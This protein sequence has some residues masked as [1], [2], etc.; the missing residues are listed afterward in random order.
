[1]TVTVGNDTSCKLAAST[2]NGRVYFPGQK[3][4]W[5]KR[6]MK[7]RSVHETLGEGGGTLKLSVQ[8]GAIKVRHAKA[9]G[10]S[11]DDDS[12]ESD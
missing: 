6:M 5:I 12:D 1:M 8:N 10:D 3:H 9:D 2:V 4:A 11:D 7:S